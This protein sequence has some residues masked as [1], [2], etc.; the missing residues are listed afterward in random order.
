VQRRKHTPAFFARNNIQRAAD[1]RAAEPQKQQ[2]P[3]GI[4]LYN[5]APCVIVEVKRI[6]ARG[7]T[8]PLTGGEL[9][10]TSS[11]SWPGA[12][13]LLPGAAIRLRL[14]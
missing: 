14:A 12:R 9:A 4:G 7:A 5:H 10:A 1:A 3:S 13:Y 11:R 2:K 8:P 6:A